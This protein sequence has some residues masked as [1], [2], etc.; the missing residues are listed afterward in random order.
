MEKI[1]VRQ[2]MEDPEKGREFIRKGMLL[3]VKAAIYTL[4]QVLQ[5]SEMQDAYVESQ[6]R[7]F[8]AFY[9]KQKA[10]PSLFDLPKVDRHA[11]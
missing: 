9:E 2:L 11:V 8:V 3:D 1:D 6:W 7:R 5:S 10:E 4:N